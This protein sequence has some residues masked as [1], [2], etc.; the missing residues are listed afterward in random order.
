[1]KKM[2]LGTCKRGFVLGKL[3]FL[4][5]TIVVG[6]CLATAIFAEPQ[7]RGEKMTANAISVSERLESVLVVGEYAE[8]EVAGIVWRVPVSGAGSVARI[9]PVDPLRLQIAGFVLG[10]LYGDPSWRNV[11]RKSWSDHFVS[12]GYPREVAA[13]MA[14]VLGGLI[15][16]A[17]TDGLYEAAGGS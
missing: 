14:D 10:N 3:A 11:D 17:R 4:L 9:S 2:G 5:A 15:A 12:I 13:E 16:L 6:G 1:M 7:R 8:I